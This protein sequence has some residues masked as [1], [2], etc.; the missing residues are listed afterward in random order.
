[1]AQSPETVAEY[2]RNEANGLAY[3]DRTCMGMNA[4]LL[5]PH[6][7]DA[8]LFAAYT[9]L[10][11]KPLVVVT[12]RTVPSEEIRAAMD[13]LGLDWEIW[14]SLLEGL[15]SVTEDV[16]VFLPAIYED[17]H[18]EH[19]FVGRRAQEMF[20][21]G[22]L[23]SYLTYAP[24]GYRQREGTEVVPEPWMIARK[25]KALSCFESQIENPATRPWFTSP[26]LDTREWLA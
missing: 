8:C 6:G 11:E 19:N 18:E 2:W 5:D 13:V 14:P 22:H 9:C 26:L 24:R 20:A 17:G 3:T 23:T 10:R 25:L 4:I 21:P 15:R 16:R 1:M 7:D 12:H